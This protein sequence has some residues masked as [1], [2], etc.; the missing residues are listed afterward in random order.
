[1]KSEDYSNTCS[2]GKYGYTTKMDKLGHM[3]SYCVD[4]FER[5]LQES[6]SKVPSSLSKAISG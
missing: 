5:Y 3:E 2:C 6:R 1:M 4:C